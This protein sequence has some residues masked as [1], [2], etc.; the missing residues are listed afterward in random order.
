MLK[1]V[2]HDG[3]VY[4]SVRADEIGTEAQGPIRI[5]S[6]LGPSLN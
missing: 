3:E 5:K 4:V 2:Q 1:Q 6:P